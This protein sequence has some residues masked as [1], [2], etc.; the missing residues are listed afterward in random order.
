MANSDSMVTPMASSPAWIGVT[1]SVTLMLALMIGL[2]PTAAIAD[3]HGYCE[4]Y[5][6]NDDGEKYC[7]DFQSMADIKQR[8]IRLRKYCKYLQEKT[9]DSCQ[10][11]YYIRSGER[12]FYDR[13][14][15]C[16]YNDS[17]NRSE[18]RHVSD[19]DESMGSIWYIEK[20]D[21]HGSCFS[22]K[23]KNLFNNFPSI[24][25]GYPIYYVI[26]NDSLEYGGEMPDKDY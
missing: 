26:R 3:S 15:T 8:H 1:I 20:T 21:Y 12:H 5:D 11:T 2:S 4:S 17:K 7:D 14:R 25:V 18:F 23:N 6:Y 16:I 22:T 19:Y 13:V 9:N 24:G 10:V